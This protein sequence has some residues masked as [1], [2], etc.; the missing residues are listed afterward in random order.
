MLVSDAKEL[1]CFIEFNTKEVYIVTYKTK[2]GNR[3]DKLIAIG[4][5]TVKNDTVYTFKNAL[6]A[7]PIDYATKRYAE[8]KNGGL[9][10]L[11]TIKRKDIV[12]IET[13]ALLNEVEQLTADR[14]AFKSEAI[15]YA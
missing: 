14:I 9:E 4:F 11:T 6:V 7:Y 2:D 5:D 15:V 3:T 12:K 1:H 13:S 8:I 10:I